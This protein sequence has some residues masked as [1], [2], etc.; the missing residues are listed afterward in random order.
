MCVVGA[1]T[2]TRSTRPV[3]SISCATLRPKV[4]LPAAGVAEARKL[5][6]SCSA[7]AC[8]AAR[9]QAR[10]GRSEGH[11]GSDLTARRAATPVLTRGSPFFGWLGRRQ[12]R[13]G[14]GQVAE[15]YARGWS[16]PGRARSGQEVPRFGPDLALVEARRPPRVG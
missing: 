8:R 9:C 5:S 15:G 12:G 3:R 14:L 16:D 10:S 2:T 13:A 4:V 7:T 6:P 11:G 1:A